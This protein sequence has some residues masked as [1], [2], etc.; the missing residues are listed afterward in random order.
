MRNLSQRAAV[1]IGIGL[2]ISITACGG[3]GGGTTITPPPATYVLTVNSVN[4]SAGV[5][6][7]VSPADNYSATN[8]TTS[9]TRTY[10]SGAAVTLTYDWTGI[11]PENARRFG[12]PL[13]DADGLGRSL[14]LLSQACRAG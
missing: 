2:S 9:F 3:G 6:I 14:Q 7:T 11:P 12:V 10:T 4:P 13:V 5:A 8:G 1:W